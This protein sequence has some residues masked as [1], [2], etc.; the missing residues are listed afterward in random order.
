[1]YKA[2]SNVDDEVRAFSLVTTE[3]EVDPEDTFLGS[4]RLSPTGGLY[5]VRGLYTP[6]RYVG[7]TVFVSVLAL[8]VRSV[9]LRA[10]AAITGDSGPQALLAHERFLSSLTPY[11]LT[12]RVF[13]A[14]FELFCLFYYALQIMSGL[15]TILLSRRRDAKEEYRYWGSV[16]HLMKD[17]LPAL[18]SFSAMKVLKNITPPVL[19]ADLVSLLKNLRTSKEKKSGAYKLFRVGQFFLQRVFL[20]A[21]GFE[22]FL[23]KFRDVSSSLSDL[24]GEEFR[25]VFRLLIFLNQMLGVVQLNTFSNERLFRFIFGGVDNFIDPSEH[26][27]MCVWKAALVRRIWDEFKASPGKFF[28][29]AITFNDV[30]FQRLVLDDDDD[31]EPAA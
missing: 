25:A 30:D 22:A 31:D 5:E 20:F 27:K 24:H 6:V 14:W 11:R 21:F 7:A 10:V 13:V 4:L 18:Q 19:N 28:A 23:L 12:P 29:V 3:Q 15:S 1:V 17:V 26:R 16:S 8:N 9:S 2:L